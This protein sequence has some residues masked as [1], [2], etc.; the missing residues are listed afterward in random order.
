MM[1]MM[2]VIMTVMMM[3]I[4]YDV[5]VD[6]DS[7]NDS[8][9]DGYND[10]DDVA[11]DRRLGPGHRQDVQGPAGQTD[12]PFRAWLRGPGSARLYPAKRP[13]HL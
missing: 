11:G 13:A 4:I 1:V 5:D 12:H 10:N 6:G 8:D 9:N 3:M 2:T 7:D